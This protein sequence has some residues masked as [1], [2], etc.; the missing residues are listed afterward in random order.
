[1]NIYISCDMEGVDGIVTEKQSAPT[2]PFYEF[3][4]EQITAEVNAAAQ[5]AFNA[6]MGVA[7]ISMRVPGLPLVALMTPGTGGSCP[8]GDQRYIFQD[9]V[10]PIFLV[11]KILRSNATILSGAV[12]QLK[13][14]L[15]QETSEK[16]R[17]ICQREFLSFLE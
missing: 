14:N 3:A 17:R 8:I 15:L 1:M 2:G 13:A 12:L 11:S 5:G 6:A 9:L 10:Q 4:R 7:S 16:E